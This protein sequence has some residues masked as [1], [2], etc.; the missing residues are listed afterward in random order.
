MNQVD[1]RIFLHHNDKVK[2]LNEDN[3]WLAALLSGEA[4]KEKKRP[5]AKKNRIVS[6]SQR[7]AI[8][9]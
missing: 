2:Q 6:S 5:P 8:G 1:I 3:E 7:K 4:F 9:R